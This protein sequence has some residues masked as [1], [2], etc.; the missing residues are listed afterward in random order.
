MSHNLY[1]IVSISQWTY[2]PS[3]IPGCTDD[4]MVYNILKF[5][6]LEI[7]KDLM[8]VSKGFNACSQAEINLRYQMLFE[9]YNHNAIKKFFGRLAASETEST[10]I[11]F[12]K[13]RLLDRLNEA[14]KTT[15]L[16]NGIGKE[17]F[18]SML[19][20]MTEYLSIQPA[21]KSKKRQL[22]IKKGKEFLKPTLKNTVLLESKGD[23]YGPRKR[24]MGGLKRYK[25]GIPVF[26][27]GREK[28][29]QALICYFEKGGHLN[30]VVSNTSDTKGLQI[31]ELTTFYKNGNRKDCLVKMKNKGGW[32]RTL[33]AT[34]YENGN[35]KSRESEDRYPE[36]VLLKRY[37]TWDETGKNIKRPW[38]GKK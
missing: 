12:I 27:H 3:V 30:A 35:K 9:P 33:W 6:E 11:K 5:S 15:I 16:R 7:F 4:A 20:P 1:K 19:V 24:V 10:G 32:K 2:V 21:F 17:H 31:M 26:I 13:L 18:T 28:N 14:Y 37:D 22:F 34:F 36:G 38:T 25:V 29:K 8:L 23:L